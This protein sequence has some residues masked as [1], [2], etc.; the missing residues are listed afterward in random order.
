MPEVPATAPEWAAPSRVTVLDRITFRPENEANDTAEART[1][2]LRTTIN[3]VVD[4]CN[5]LEAALIP[6]TGGTL[7]S[8]L[9]MGGHYITGSGTADHPRDLADM[10]YILQAQLDVL[11]TSDALTRCIRLDGSREPSSDLDMGDERIHNAG[12]AV[13]GEPASG[14]SKQFFDDAVQNARTYLLPRVGAPLMS[15]DLNMDAG[16]SAP[17]STRFSGIRGLP[18]PVA[19]DEP[20]TMSY[21]VAKVATLVPTT[22]PVGLIGICAGDPTILPA[23]WL[24]ADGRNMSKAGYAALDTVCGTTYGIG[25]NAGLFRIPDMRGR[26]PIGVS[27]EHALG[28]LEGADRHTLLPAELPAHA[29]DFSDSLNEV[30]TG[31]SIAGAVSA[32]TERGLAERFTVTASAGD[33]A[34]HDNCQP[35]IA[36]AWYILS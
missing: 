32:D 12:T 16:V 20:A 2:T 31:G 17:P 25:S 27:P 34:V 22:L 14:I 21:V 8:D 19:D 26:T 24:V 18:T 29:H 6:L 5:L 36:L 4:L 28:A 15:G 10:A 9:D 1:D 3:A 11:D 23:R 7:S 13:L 30:G 35:S 33:S